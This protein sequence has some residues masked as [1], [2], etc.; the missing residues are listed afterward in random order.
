VIAEYWLTTT[1]KY[2][3]DRYKKKYCCVVT[4]NMAESGSAEGPNQ[5]K[6]YYISSMVVLYISRPSSV[7]KIN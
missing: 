3:I 1:H 5:A 4:Q 6:S 2:E 7:K